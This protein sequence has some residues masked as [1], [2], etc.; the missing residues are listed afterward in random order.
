VGGR[1]HFS[2]QRPGRTVAAQHRHVE[3]ADARG[4]CPRTERVQ[5]RGA[6]AAVLPVIDH[7]DRDFGRLEVV[8]AHVTGDPD[9]RPR[10]R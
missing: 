1:R 2:D 8:E 9:R 5:E 6:H 4:A 3:A 7:L 10:W